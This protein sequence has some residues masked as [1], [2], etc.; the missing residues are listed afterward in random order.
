MCI[1]NA[2]IV[3]FL[4]TFWFARSRS[5]NFNLASEP[6]GRVS[7]D[8]LRA[9]DEADPSQTTEK[10]ASQFDVTLLTI[11]THLHDL[12]SL[13]TML[14]TYSSDTCIIKNNIFG[15]IKRLR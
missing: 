7:N 10:L 1:T 11:P 13:A 4:Y 8:E 3:R 12:V 14:T 9:I 6:W 15:K 2:C 5:E